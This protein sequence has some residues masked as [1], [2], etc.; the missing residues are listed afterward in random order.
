MNLSDFNYHLPDERIA[1]FPS[2]QRTSSRLLCLENKSDSVLHRQFYEVFNLIEEGDLLV[3]NNT[4]VIP[5]RLFGQKESGGKV[6]ILVE[7]ILDEHRALVHLR[8]SKSPKQ[9]AI[10]IFSE[11][12]RAEILGR[13]N[14]LF[15][16]KFLD[17]DSLLIILEK[18][19]HVPLPPYMNR[20]DVGEDH[21]RYQTV[22]AKHPGAVAAPTAG[23]HFDKELLEKLKNK[24]VEIAFVTLHV[25]AG[26]FQPV[27]VEKIEEHVMHAEYLEVSEEVCE[28]IKS[29]NAKG[30]RVI[31]VGTTSVRCLETAARDGLMKPF[32]GDTQL[33]I[34]PGFQFQCVDV[35]IT[36]FHL[37]CSTL[38]MLVCAFAGYQKIMG[39]Y[40]E[41]IEQ[42][43]RFFSYGDAMWIE[44][45]TNEI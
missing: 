24:G 11:N 15:E 9:G 20:E 13:Q 44:R 19:G 37:P 6:E 14:D 26:T 22:Y 7:R 16:L 33:F 18:I 35:L 5:A 1:R 34:Y 31:A 12:I 23:L 30:K 42:E 43:Y 17:V 38:L 4:R 8:S 27:R 32:T 41:A 21:E 10:I 39:A 29:A 2:P 36:N 28:K 25:G 40:Q 3:L 45:C